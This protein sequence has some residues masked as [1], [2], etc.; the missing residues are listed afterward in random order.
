[1]KTTSNARG[2]DLKPL[3]LLDVVLSWPLEDVLNENLYEDKVLKIPETFESATDYKNSFIPLLFEE[4]RADLSPSLSAVSRAPFC[5]IKEVVSSQQLKL[6]KAPKEFKQFRHIIQ[7][8]S[9]T[10]TG[11]D[12]ENY[13][14]GNGDLIVFTNIRPKSL[15]DLNT[16]KS[17][18]HI[19]YVV[20][21]KDRYDRISVLS[22]K[23]MKMFI[24]NEFRNNNEQKLYAL[25]LI[26]ITTNIRTS[27]TLN[28]PHRATETKVVKHEEVFFFISLSWKWFL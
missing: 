21:A 12:G 13:E 15:D 19:A 17:P 1:M 26:N 28:S 9:T 16:L 8:K 14:P 24:E 3:R 4:T 20:H 11:E 10:D 6:P 23:C 25:H 2:D 22:S 18:Y 7:L 27:D 5:E